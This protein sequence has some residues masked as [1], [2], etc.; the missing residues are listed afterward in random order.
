MAKDQKG[1]GKL[2]NGLGRSIKTKHTP[3]RTCVI[4][5]SKKIKPE[6][7]RIFYS[8]SRGIKVDTSNKFGGRGAYI[9]KIGECHTENL[10][11]S[12]IELTLK[13]QFTNANWDQLRQE[14]SGK[15]IYD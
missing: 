8:N 3:W 14:I 11:K 6:L 13:E 7:I 9:C 4:C 1:I 2:I 5:R 15:I 12:R 10:N